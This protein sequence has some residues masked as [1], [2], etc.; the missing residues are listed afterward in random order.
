MMMCVCVNIAAD[1]FENKFWTII[2]FFEEIARFL[3]VEM[4][5][6]IIWIVN[7]G[8]VPPHLPN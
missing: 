1:T 7:V 3:L 6:I 5:C 2:Y 4:I 8:N